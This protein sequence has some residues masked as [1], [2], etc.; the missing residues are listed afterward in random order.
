MRDPPNCKKVVKRRKTKKEFDRTVFSL[1]LSLMNSLV[2]LSFAQ[3]VASM[4]ASEVA[5]LNAWCDE[6]AADA[7]A[8]M[9]EFDG[10][11]RLAALVDTGAL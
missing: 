11:N 3:E 7:L 5:E 4:T 9:D 6:L 8:S 1:M 10:W 2:S